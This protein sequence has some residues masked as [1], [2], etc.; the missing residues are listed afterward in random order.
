MYYGMGSG[1]CTCRSQGRAGLDVL[2]PLP[3]VT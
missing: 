2:L 1:S 3:A